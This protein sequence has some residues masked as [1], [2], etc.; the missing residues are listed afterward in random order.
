MQR[1]LTLCLCRFNG[2]LQMLAQQL[3]VSPADIVDFEL[4]VCD[5]QPGT[6]GGAC[7]EFVLAGMVWPRCLAVHAFP[8]LCYAWFAHNEFL[9]N[10]QQETFAFAR[11][12]VARGRPAATFAR[13][14]HNGHFMIAHLLAQH[15]C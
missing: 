6:I 8:W 12:R 10:L 9:P 13:M 5:V 7:D 14:L 15:L 3:Q 1:R 4:H 11:A 2:C